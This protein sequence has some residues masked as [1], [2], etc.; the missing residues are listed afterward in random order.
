LK[1]GGSGSAIGRLDVTWPGASSLLK[2]A[3]ISPKTQ[4]KGPFLYEILKNEA[5]KSNRINEAVPEKPKN[6]AKKSR[7]DVIQPDAS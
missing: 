7:A 5:K 6:E 4:E 2:K 1:A 3:H